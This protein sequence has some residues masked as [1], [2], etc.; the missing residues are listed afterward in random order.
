[1]IQNIADYIEFVNNQVSYHLRQADRLMS[2]SS[3]GDPRKQQAAKKHKEVAEKLQHI[4]QFLEKADDMPAVVQE[5][6]V[7]SPF[8]HF[9]PD[10]LEGLP[11]ELL[12]ELNISESDQL[13]L[14]VY[15]ALEKAGGTLPVDK[16]LIQLYRDTGKVFSRNKLAAKLYR[17]ASKGRLVS[18]EER[19]VYSLPDEKSIKQGTFSSLLDEEFEEKEDDFLK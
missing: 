9:L 18:E 10:D 14:N 5:D 13:E 16:I 6:S 4:S 1:V 15:K 3:V 19:G 12:D 8:S 2:G 17:M 7:V 11:Q